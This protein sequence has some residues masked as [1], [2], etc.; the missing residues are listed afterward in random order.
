MKLHQ[1]V[2]TSFFMILERRGEQHKRGKRLSYIFTNQYLIYRYIVI[3]AKS[4]GFALRL[5]DF[6]GVSR[7]CDEIS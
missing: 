6:S 2:L 7:E 4:R 5:K 1:S 3:V